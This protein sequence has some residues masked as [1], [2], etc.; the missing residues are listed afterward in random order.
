MENEGTAQGGFS[1]DSSGPAPGTG[2]V[3]SAR[4][5]M[6]GIPSPVTACSR[7]CLGCP[8]LLFHH[9]SS[10][11]CFNFCLVPPPPNL[12]PA[13]LPQRLLGRPRDIAWWVGAQT[14]NAA[15]APS[16]MTLDKLLACLHLETEDDDSHSNLLPGAVVRTKSIESVCGISNSGPCAVSAI[17]VSAVVFEEGKEPL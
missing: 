3:P 17:S 12:A 6:L 4:R 13:S 1:K 2:A 10:P 8:P 11:V 7:F 14:L 15:S 5:A 9:G 16:C